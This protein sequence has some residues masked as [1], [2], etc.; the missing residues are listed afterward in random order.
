ML[1]KQTSLNIVTKFIR[2]LNWTNYDDEI[3]LTH[4]KLGRITVRK[5]SYNHSS[6]DL[7]R[8]IRRWHKDGGVLIVGHR[9]FTS[10]LNSNAIAYS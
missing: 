3:W 5:V 6:T 4:R 1:F 10:M 9:T 2:N 7:Q 8:I